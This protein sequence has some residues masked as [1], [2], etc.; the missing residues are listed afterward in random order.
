MD[1]G[2]GEAGRPDG[3]AAPQVVL[4]GDDLD[5]LE[6]VLG[7]ALPGS[8]RL[9]AARDGTGAD[10]VVLTDAENTPL[11]V[12]RRPDGDRLAIEAL[13][14]MARGSGLAWDPAVR[15]SARDVRADLERPDAV[16]RVVAL[17]IDDLP[18][19]TDVAI[20]EG[21]VGSSSATAVLFVVPVA[22]RSTQLP[23]AIQGSALLRAAQ[24]FAQTLEASHPSTPINLLALPWPAG[25]REL[26]LAEVLAAYGASEVTRLRDVRSPAEAQRIA[27]LSQTFE[28]AVRDLY[29]DA[30]ATE[31][32]R[33]IQDRPSRG[34]VVL[35]TGLSGS[36]KSTIARAL[37]DTIADRD[38]RAV[39]LLDGDE[40]RQHL[41][42]GLGFDVASRE[43][44]VARIAYVASLVATHGGLA[45]AA[46]I[47]PFAA[48]RL[49][50]RRL[51][52]PD[53]GV[54][55]RPRRHP[56]R[57]LRGARSQGPVRQ[58]TGRADRRLHRDLLSLRAT[59]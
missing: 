12:L 14:P 24:A 40:V 50:A 1:E 47:A 15:R 6:L 30:S 43:M 19:R 4:D 17:V 57:G 21:L 52:E 22:R 23:A 53:R 35:F 34:A 46:P 16:D 55:A 2:A 10:E 59:G 39:T 3:P 26:H 5:V 33:A 56:A 48:G 28:Q 20:V 27:D 25:D 51:I 45:V 44:N 42:A 31:L 9:D 7:G 37:A 18:T 29:P 8:A 54:S 11:A 58:G 38:G 36:G 41:S 13:R 32:L 49:A